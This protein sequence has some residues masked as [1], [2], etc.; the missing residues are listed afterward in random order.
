MAVELMCSWDDILRWR[1]E[2]LA[3]HRRVTFRLVT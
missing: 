2:Y 3:W 1:A